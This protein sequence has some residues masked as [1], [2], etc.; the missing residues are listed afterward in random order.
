VCVGEGEGEEEVEKAR[1]LLEH[2]PSV[3][4]RPDELLSSHR[5]DG[6]LPQVCI[7]LRDGHIK[8]MEE[9]LV[10][11]LTEGESRL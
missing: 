10:A 2:G 6:Q 5:W 8:G 9:H 1:S 11:T 4:A 3:E 7:D